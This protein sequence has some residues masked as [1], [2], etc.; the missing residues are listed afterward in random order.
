[1]LVPA[2]W[3]VEQRARQRYFLPAYGLF[4]FMMTFAARDADGPFPPGP[5]RVRLKIDAVVR[6]SAAVR[7]QQDRAI[8]EDQTAVES[9]QS[10][11][12]LQTPHSHFLSSTPFCT[13]H[14]L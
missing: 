13:V 12:E 8:C 14:L 5:H 9:A 1:M 6:A 7:R 10:D 2:C 11:F 3:E 4:S